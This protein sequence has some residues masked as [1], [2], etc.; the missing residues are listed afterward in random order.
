M[1]TRMSSAIPPFIPASDIRA[2][3]GNALGRIRSEEGLT[4]AELAEQ[5]G[6]GDDQATRY[7]DGS[8]EM[9]ASTL[10]RAKQLWN[11]RFTGEADQLI[12]RAAPTHDGQQ[13]QSCLL[14]AA[15]NLSIALQ[16]GQLTDAEIAANRSDLERCGDAIA[17]LLARLGPKGVRA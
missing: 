1:R 17:A 7:V 12:G 2:A 6:K 3:L 13:V 15:F 14:K 9:G 10:Y 5:L 16:D 4:W 11:G 8:S